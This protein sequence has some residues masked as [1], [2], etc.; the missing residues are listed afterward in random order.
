MVFGRK[1]RFRSGGGHKATTP[2]RDAASYRRTKPTE[3]DITSEAHHAI[4]VCHHCGG[5]LTDKQEYIRYI[6]DVI[7]SALSTTTQFKTV[8]KHTIERGYCVS[9]GKHSSAQDLRGSE[10]TLGPNVRTLICYLITLRDHSYDQVQ[11]VLWDIYRFK[12]TDGEII[13]VLDA[14]RL[15]LLPAYEALK[16]SIRAGPAVHMDESRWRIQS[17]KAGYAWSM[18]S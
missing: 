9:C 12:I 15:E 3:D 2:A 6:E 11:N 4:D 16:E 5:P 7:L 17:E 10:V 18:R 13:N 8:E 14:R 1:N